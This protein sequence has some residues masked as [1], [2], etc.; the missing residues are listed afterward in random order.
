MSGRVS[1]VDP[2][3]AYPLLRWASG[4]VENVHEMARINRQF[5]WMPP[6]MVLAAIYAGA[7]TRC[8]GRYPRADRVEENKE[9]AARK[10]ILMKYYEWSEQEYERSDPEL[11]LSRVDIER[12]AEE[13][14]VEVAT[15]KSKKK[16]ARR[17][18]R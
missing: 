11:V 13:L 7:V 10:E 12:M 2:G 1:E 9:A 6:E 14:G 5:F 17:K 4:P 18:K 3:M 16:R 15:G 8:I